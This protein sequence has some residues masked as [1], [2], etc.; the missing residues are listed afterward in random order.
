MLL[1][2]NL[3]PLVL[4][5]TLSP[6]LH[7]HQALLPRPIQA[8]VDPRRSI[9]KILRGS[10][11]PAFCRLGSTW[12]PSSHRLPG[13]CA[14]RRTQECVSY[15]RPSH[16]RQQR[17]QRLVGKKV[18]EEVLEGGGNEKQEGG[19]AQDDQCPDPPRQH[20]RY[21]GGDS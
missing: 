4:L 21:H 19:T 9:D 11:C 12:R 15:Q 14:H 17:M 5:L 20:P 10:P 3:V 2:N 16:P 7:G 13:G 8:D 6:P 1:K 18:L